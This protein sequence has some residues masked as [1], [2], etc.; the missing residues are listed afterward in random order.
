MG[1]A[2]ENPWACSSLFIAGHAEH[3]GGPLEEIHK[4]EPAKV[5]SYPWLFLPAQE[6][7]RHLAQ[8]AQSRRW[9]PL[10]AAGR[11]VPR[12]S[13]AAPE[14]GRHCIGQQCLSSWRAPSCCC[15][16]SK[17]AGSPAWSKAK[18]ACDGGID[19]VTLLRLQREAEVEQPVVW[20]DA[21]PRHMHPFAGCGDSP[22][23]RH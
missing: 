17:S 20:E 3:H 13:A 22:F 12:T 4:Q 19:T 11:A 16:K 18:S 5:F 2:L 8:G 7:T 1:I 21:L 23:I 9:E 15:I 6:F 14:V 10:G